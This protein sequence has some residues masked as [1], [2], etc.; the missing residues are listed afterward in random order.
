MSVTPQP[1]AFSLP[2]IKIGD[3]STPACAELQTQF[4]SSTTHHLQEKQILNMPQSTHYL[5]M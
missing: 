5:V 1:V 3:S 4:H 2:S